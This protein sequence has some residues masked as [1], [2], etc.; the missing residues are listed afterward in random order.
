MRTCLVREKVTLTTRWNINRESGLW[1]D[2]FLIKANYTVHMLMRGY[3]EKNLMGQCTRG[4]D[5][6]NTLL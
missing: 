3:Y 4:M 5:S 6:S 1:K 2:R